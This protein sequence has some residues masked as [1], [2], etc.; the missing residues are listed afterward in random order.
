MSWHVNWICQENFS[1]S[2]LSCM[3]TKNSRTD[4]PKTFHIC[5][6]EEIDPGLAPFDEDLLQLHVAEFLFIRRGSGEI[7]VDLQRYLLVENNFYFLSPGQYRRLNPAGLLEGYY[8]ALS[9]DFVYLL[10]SGTKVPFFD[11]DFC[12]GEKLICATPDKQAIAELE[13]TLRVILK[14]YQRVSE[15]RKQLLCAYTGIFLLYLSIHVGPREKNLFCDREKELTRNFLTLVKDNF[16]AKKMVGD[17][18]ADLF[19]SSNYLNQ[20]VKRNTGFTASHHIQQRVISEAK[21]RAINAPFKLK[22]IAYALG[23]EDC[24]HFSKYF[25]SKCGMSFTKF[26]Q[27]TIRQ[28]SICTTISAISSSGS[29]L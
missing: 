15:F 10:N 21:R 28:S 19:I 29:L 2:K 6:L 4:Q 9:P 22:E 18:A 20:V 1:T 27:E 11:S 13:E 24:A 17:Y 26:K 12:I 8:M 5:R 3:A 16:T 7:E 25:K 23:F 14:V